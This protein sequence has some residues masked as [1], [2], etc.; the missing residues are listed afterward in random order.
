MCRI[1]K[2]PSAFQP[3]TR[4]LS[5][6]AYYSALPLP[7]S[8]HTYERKTNKTQGSCTRLQLYYIKRRKRNATHQR[9]KVPANC[10][11]TMLS[12]R[13]PLYVPLPCSF[14][15]SLS[16][17]Y[18]LIASSL[19][20]PHTHT[21][22]HSSSCS[23]PFRDIR[24]SYHLLLGQASSSTRS[25]LS[26]SLWVGPANRSAFHT[27]DAADRHC[28]ASRDEARRPPSAPINYLNC[29]ERYK[30]LKEVWRPAG[31]GQGPLPLGPTPRNVCKAS[32]RVRN[33]YSLETSYSFRHRCR[34]SPLGDTLFYA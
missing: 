21:C 26:R 33:S 31:R 8:Y 2:Y 15:L 19:L 13:A 25:W 28:L 4:P 5:N 22:T 9:R 18:P 29:D 27:W 24:L 1:G 34:T 10:T 11:H 20:H 17:L 32:T 23:L 6:Q 3:L 14:S 7:P 30:C 16:R 12:L